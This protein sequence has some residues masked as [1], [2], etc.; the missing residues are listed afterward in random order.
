MQ[1]KADNKKE[2]AKNIAIVCG[3]RFYILAL[4]RVLQAPEELRP[5]LQ[6]LNINLQ[7]YMKQHCM[8]GDQVQAAWLSLLSFLD[9]IT[10]ISLVDVQNDTNLDDEIDQTLG[11]A[12]SLE[13]MRILEDLVRK[14]NPNLEL[15][16]ICNR[17]DD[18]KAELIKAKHEYEYQL[19]ATY[20]AFKD[21]IEK[22]KEQEEEE[23]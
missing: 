11:S 21:Y 14:N 23:Q 19:F 16:V 10:A 13:D 6:D 2:E 22:Y 15:L 4:Q 1:K 17:L 9:M 8:N 20:K 12:F 3:R 7:Q 18:K 5:A